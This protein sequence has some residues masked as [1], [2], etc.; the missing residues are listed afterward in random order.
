[1]GAIAAA[2]NVRES[3]ISSYTCICTEM[4]VKVVS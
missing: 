3:I 4:Q 1:M 2:L